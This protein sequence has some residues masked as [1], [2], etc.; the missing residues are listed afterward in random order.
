MLNKGDKVAGPIRRRVAG[1]LA[2]A[3]GFGILVNSAPA[4][5]APAHR[6]HA[7]TAAAPANTSPGTV[8]FAVDW[9]W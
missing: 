6:S 4:G 9:W 1:I 2:I 7:V 5:A 8:Q 3:M